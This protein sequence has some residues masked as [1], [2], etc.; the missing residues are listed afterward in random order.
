MIM[1]GFGL[2][3]LMLGGVSIVSYARAIAGDFA[4]SVQNPM[5][6]VVI[7]NT[8][9]LALFVAIY[10]LLMRSRFAPES[11]DSA[12]AAQS[13]GDPDLKALVENAPDIIARFNQQLHYVYINPAI[14]KDTG[15]SAQTFIG[16]TIA[17]MPFLRSGMA[18]DRVGTWESALNKVFD[19]GQEE[20]LESEYLTGRGRRSYQSRLVPERAADGSI[21][22]V[23]SISRDI[24][25]LKN[26]RIESPQAIAAVPFEE[27]GVKEA[28]DEISDSNREPTRL[29]PSLQQRLERFR[30][31]LKNLP[32]LLFIQDT[33]LRYTWVYDCAS[34]LDNEAAIAKLESEINVSEDAQRLAAI[35]RYVMTTGVGIGE[36]TLMRLNGEAGYY[37]LNVEPL[38]NSVGEVVGISGAAMKLDQQHLREQQLQAIFE[39]AIEAI[40][41]ADDRGYYV[42]VNPAAGQLFGLP[43]SELVGKRITEFMD[44]EFDFE[45]AWRNFQGQGQATGELN[46]VRPD[47]SVRIVE[48]AAKA[49]FIPGRHLS[50]LRDITHRKQS[51]EALQESEER[52]R[53]ALEAAH[54]GT[55]DWNIVT[56][57]VSWSANQELLYGMEPG[58]FD[59]RYE[60]FTNSIHPEDRDRVL[61]ALERAIDRHEEYDIEFRVVWPNGIVRVSASKG[62]V[63]YDETGRALRMAGVDIDITE[64]YQDREVVRQSQNLLQ[65]I[66]DTIPNHLYIYDLDRNC[67]VYTNRQMQKFFNCTHA[68]IKT[69]GSQLLLHILHPEDVGKLGELMTRFQ[70]AEDGEILENEFRLKNSQGEW[71]WFRT[72]E[73]IFSRTV[74]GHPEQVLGTAIDITER[75]NAEEA[76]RKS[77]QLYRTM[78][79]NFPNGAVILFDRDLR[80]TLA[81][82]QGL[83]DIG[84]SKALL[85]GKT[86]WEV[87]SPQECEI[88]EPP[89]RAALEGNSSVVETLY[90]DKIYW[91]HVLPVKNESG[92]IFAGMVMAQDISDRKRAE[93]A[94]LEERNFVSAILDTAGA[95]VVVLDRSGRIVRF[96]R[97]CEEVTGYSFDE[98]RG[99]YLW[100]LFLIPEEVELVKAVFE[101][102]LAGQ[103]PQEYENYWVG[104]NGRRRAIS[105]SNT[106]LLDDRGSVKYAIATGI[107][108]TERKRSAEIRRALE[109]EHELSQLQIRFFTMVSHEFRTPLSTILMSAQ[110]LENG[111]DEW[112][113]SKKIKNLQRI[114]TSVKH[115]IHLLDDILTINRAETGQ[116]EFNPICLNVD[117]FCFDFVEAMQDKVGSNRAI[118]F[119]KNRSVVAEKKS[120]ETQ[121]ESPSLDAT[122]AYL[123]ETLLR[124]ILSNSMANAIKYSSPNS[125]VYLSLI[126]TSKEAIFTIRDEGIGIYPEDQTKIFEP[127]YRGQNV[128][129]IPGSGLGLTV[130][131]KCVDL[132]GGAIALKSEVGMGTTFT[133]TLPRLHPSDVFEA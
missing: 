52:L 96:N 40:A 35:K 86:I 131:K 53:L 46:L 133:V 123:D 117:K 132:H 110:I 26:K 68:E 11:G 50:I 29:I 79:S 77:E 98:V 47:S 129:M 28:I 37:Y 89:Y 39:E 72:W 31:T 76:L 1:G 57:K 102:L 88:L 51:Q 18:E 41:I 125:P 130:V 116:L 90:R 67:N 4:Q 22:Y 119:I 62:Q 55:W 109:R 24:T 43:A 7:G 61:Q 74:D 3:L 58:S 115:M 49:S 128:E 23:L 103:C 101:K 99:A 16:K 112:L 54:M 70:S 5:Q 104:R 78:T 120:S 108:I 93:Q 25:E 17:E 36:Q 10:Y 59:G 27:I 8:C 122:K 38:Q 13:D 126:C 32:I 66:A 14:E 81:E 118:K 107:D 34:G 113:N 65:Q 9:S 20:S 95:L 105:W 75:K 87:L 91:V 92:E 45:T 15:I 42:E 85:E 124:S 94:L 97:A 69:M 71:R 64:R 106:V 73:I 121:H 56:G 12:P 6:W 19:T 48:Y 84:L 33:D 30:Q 80:Y 82:G 44:R 60:T 2:A 21:K 127:F 83:A 114:Q 63:F 100:D 111:T